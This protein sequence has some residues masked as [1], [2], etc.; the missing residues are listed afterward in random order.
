MVWFTS[1]Q[2]QDTAVHPHTDYPVQTTD[3]GLKVALICLDE[4]FDYF[5]LILQ[6]NLD[7][8]NQQNL[9]V[10]LIFALKIYAPHCGNGRKQHLEHRRPKRPARIN[11]TAVH[12]C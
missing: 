2:I 6:L 11:V 7:I 4:V 1:A 9:N 8:L 12:S 3:G 5:R 10:S